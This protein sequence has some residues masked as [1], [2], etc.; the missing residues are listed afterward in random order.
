M[1]VS[2]RSLIFP[3][4]IGSAVCLVG[5]SSID[6]EDGCIVQNDVPNSHVTPTLHWAGM[7][8]GG[9]KHATG[10]KARTRM[11]FIPSVGLG[12]EGCWHSW[13]KEHLIPAGH[14]ALRTRGQLAPSLIFLPRCIQ[15]LQTKLYILLVERLK[16][17][18]IVLLPLPNLHRT[19]ADLLP[20]CPRL[21]RPAPGFTMPQK[22]Q[23]PTS[24]PVVG[25]YPR[26]EERIDER[27]EGVDGTER[28]GALECRW[29]VGVEGALRSK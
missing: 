11:I 28:D 1:D 19:L 15:L 18:G 25:V 5:D 23:R 29:T 6:N 13:V 17:V 26:G 24:I 4:I 10:S 22:I 8:I 16:F 7:L 12:V 3:C 14:N 2:G 21:Q 9:T 20:R 27:K